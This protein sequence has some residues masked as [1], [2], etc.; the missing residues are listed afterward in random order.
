MDLDIKIYTLSTNETQIE[1]IIKNYNGVFWKQPSATL[2]LRV[3]QRVTK[4]QQA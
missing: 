2:P 4:I 1:I 3:V